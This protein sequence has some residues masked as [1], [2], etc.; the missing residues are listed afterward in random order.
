MKPNILRF[1]FWRAKLIVAGLYESK[2]KT[3]R[4][5]VNDELTIELYPASGSD[6]R[7]CVKLCRNTEGE[8]QAVTI[9][10]KEIPLLVD[11]LPRTIAQLMA[12]G[13]ERPSQPSII[14]PMEFIKSR[15]ELV[16]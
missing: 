5:Q 2:D 10:L 12:L 7:P 15:P 4:V 6:K 11:L 9:Y 13:T 14:P 16:E 3:T 8:Q 1:W